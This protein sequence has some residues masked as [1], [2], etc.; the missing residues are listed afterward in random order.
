MPP[1]QT[2]IV[3]VSNRQISRLVRLFKEFAA[4]MAPALFPD[5]PNP[6]IYPFW[7]ALSAALEVL[8]KRV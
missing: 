2:L 1:S 6:S 4:Q 5:L 8:P 7:V 3:H